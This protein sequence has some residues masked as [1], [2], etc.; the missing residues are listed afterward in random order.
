MLETGKHFDLL[1]M[2]QS[3]R[4]RAIESPATQG[5]H[6]HVHGELHGVALGS[7]GGLH[8]VDSA[9]SHPRSRVRRLTS[10]GVED[11]DE[12]DL[13]VRQCC[14]E[15]RPKCTRSRMNLRNWDI[16]DSALPAYP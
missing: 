1:C 8:G 13:E 15:P 2:A 14:R 11:L 3:S 7:N 9:T 16:I 4:D 12:H 5:Q 10:P 6:M